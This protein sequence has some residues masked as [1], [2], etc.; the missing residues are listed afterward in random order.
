[1]SVF[2]TVYV[3]NKRK[4]IYLYVYYINISPARFLLSHL[5]TLILVNKKI[6]KGAL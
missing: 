1:M 6:N 2:F 5:Q 4:S 3:N